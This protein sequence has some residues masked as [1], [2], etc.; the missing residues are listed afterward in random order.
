MIENDVIKLY[1]VHD[2]D[3]Q[4]RYFEYITCDALRATDSD[5]AFEVPRTLWET[6]VKAKQTVKDSEKEIDNYL[7]MQRDLGVDNV[8]DANLEMFKNWMYKNHSDWKHN[9]RKD[10]AK[11]L[12]ERGCRL[13]EVPV[14][15]DGVPVEFDEHGYP[16]TRK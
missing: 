12:V 2:W 9:K 4:D 15:P 10:R 1:N 13:I 6:Y 5:T 16:I 11:K 14:W 8:K 7:R 3:A